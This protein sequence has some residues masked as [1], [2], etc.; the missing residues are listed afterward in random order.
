MKK[1]KM[2]L[3]DHVLY[4]YQMGNLKTPAMAITSAEAYTFKAT[5]RIIKVSAPDAQ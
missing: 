4:V 2:V 5:E 3:Y 1:F